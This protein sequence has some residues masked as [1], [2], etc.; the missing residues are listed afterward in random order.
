MKLTR[1]QQQIQK[2][3][4][5]FV[6]GEFKKEVLDQLIDKLVDAKTSPETPLSSILSKAADLGFLGIH[7]PERYDGEGLGY[8]EQAIIARELARGHSTLGSALALA[9]YGADL[10]LMHG[11]EEQKQ[12]WLPGIAGGEFLVALAPGNSSIGNGNSVNNDSGQQPPEAVRDG[13]EWVITGTR[14]LVVN[15]CDRAGVFLVPC[16]TGTDSGKNRSDTRF[17]LIPAGTPG[18]SFKDPDKSL[19]LALLPLSQVTF[20]KVRVPGANLISPKTNKRKQAR[21]FGAE[22]EAACSLSVSALSL[23]TA[24]G[25]FDRAFAHVRQRQQFGKKLIQ[26]QITRHKLSMMATRIGM[27]ELLVRKAAA[28]LDKG[29]NYIKACAMARLAAGRSAVEVCDEALQLFGGYGYIREY[30]IEAYYR[31]AKML[32]LFSGGP[33]AVKEILAEQII[34]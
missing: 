5:D 32:E 3:V 34:K 18:L 30:E 23:G 16:K 11:S 13:D 31:D 27:A 25:A 19:G 21:D 10:L 29:K 33:V 2:A 14:S 12:T 20:D 15:G 24:Q 9:G 26:F 6:K 28:A 22:V 7:I 4:R 8:Q 17:F 1:E